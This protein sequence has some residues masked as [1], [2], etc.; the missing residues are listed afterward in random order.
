MT[1]FILDGALFTC[2]SLNRLMFGRNESPKGPESSCYSNQASILFTESEL[3]IPRKW[4]IR[5]IWIIN[6]KHSKHLLQERN[7][8][9]SLNLFLREVFLNA[10]NAIKWKRESCS[11]LCSEFI[12]ALRTVGMY[13]RPECT[14]LNFRCKILL[15]GSHLSLVTRLW[16]II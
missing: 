2:S 7:C 14:C 8:D 1:C 15:P 16:S 4:P 6:G 10:A 13:G 5:K 11:G 12:R 9:A 3:S